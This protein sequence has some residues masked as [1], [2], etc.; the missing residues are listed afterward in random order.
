MSF[1]RLRLAVPLAALALAV[2]ACGFKSEPVGVLPSF[3]RTADDGQGRSVTVADQPT[4]IVSLDAGLTETAFAVGAGADVVGAT[5]TESYPAAARRLPVAVSSDGQPE[6][7]KI[8]RLRP[9]LILV[10]ASL[11]GQ[12]A[13]L[14]SQFHVPVYVGGNGTF[15]D[16][17]HDIAQVGVLTGFAVRGRSLVQHMQARVAAIRRGVGTEPPVRV[18]VDNGF[19]YTI[20]P[21]GPAGD[22]ITMAGGVDVA[23]DAEPG[24]P[25]PLAKLRAAKPQAY[26]AVAGRGTTLSGLRTSGATK[27]L[28]AVRSG[29]FLLI[30]ANALTDTG[31]RVVATLRQ[32]AHALHPSATLS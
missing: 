20:D 13:A 6:T 29:R 3:P 32:I 23:A 11:A 30:D 18:F 14:G 8:R 16:I 21:A 22:L 27:H 12:A 15:A 10:P 31:P 24:K 25:Y 7:A 9:D 28:P 19:F 26:L 4:R 5:G 17:E 1:C 2:S